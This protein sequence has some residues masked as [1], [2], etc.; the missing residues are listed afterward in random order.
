[1]SFSQSA[2]F[3]SEGNVM[4]SPLFPKVVIVGT[5][6]IGS[7]IGLDLV[8][9]RLCREVIGVG[10][11]PKNLRVAVRRR[12]IHRFVSNRQALSLFQSLNEDD[13]IVLA[14]PV[15]AIRDYLKLFARVR[16]KALILDVGST[17]ASIVAEARRH[18]LRFIGC[19]PIAG[20]EKAGAEAGQKGL[21]RGRLCLITPHQSSSSDLHKISR[22]W[23]V[24]GAKVIPMS[25]QRHD[26]IFSIVSHLPHAIAYSLAGAVGRMLKGADL[27]FAFS[28]LRGMT[29][30]ASSSP[31]MWRDIFL[32]NRKQVLHAIQEFQKEVEKLKKI[33]I[34]ADS[35]ALLN[36]LSK[37][38]ASRLRDLD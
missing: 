38:R 32:E 15:A 13:L 22:F 5:G 14:A 28:S 25:P 1:M 6:L 2:G 26:Q 17:K 30:I 37:A 20:T 3:L 10:R 11:D 9:G 19:H 31:E 7:S 8:S 35:A 18:R 36:F 33:L 23:R 4:R 29:R 24:L 34:K 16:V 21:F 12:A 27:R